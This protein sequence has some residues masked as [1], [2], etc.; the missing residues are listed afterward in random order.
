MQR[1]SR[2]RAGVWAAVL[3]SSLIGGP[4]LAGFSD[5]T[6]G[7]GLP[8]STGRLAGPA[9]LTGTT[10]C[11]LLL[12]RVNL[13]WSQTTSV[14]A[15]GYSVMRR[16]GA[17][18]FTQIASITGIGTT[19]YTDTTTTINTSYTYEV[20]AVYEQWTGNSPV[21]TVSTPLLCL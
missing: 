8:I 2:R 16:T 3:A 10:G 15:K 9:S 17:L 11:V 19:T 14:Y 1:P 6:A 5:T 21:L 4:A 7:A 18:P 13:S 20:R 12:P